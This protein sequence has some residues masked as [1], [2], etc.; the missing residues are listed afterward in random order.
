MKDMR[1][2]IS[3]QNSI[4]MASAAIAVTATMAASKRETR[5]WNRTSRGFTMRPAVSIRMPASAER[6][7]KRANGANAIITT[8]TA[9]A[10]TT[11]DHCVRAPA[12]WFTADR[13]REPDPGIDWKKLP[14]RLATPSLRH[15]WLRSSFW[16]VT[17]AIACAE[18]DEVAFLHISYGQRTEARERTAFNDIADFYGVKKRLDI[19]ILKWVFFKLVF[20]KRISAARP[21]LCQPALS[22]R[23]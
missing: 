10:D 11:P 3:T 9:T 13:V 20:I 1:T 19:S 2:P 17:A 21:C 22:K 12:C 16:C 6:G 15:C 5:T 23:K 8:A 4:E 7:M 14:T 18:N